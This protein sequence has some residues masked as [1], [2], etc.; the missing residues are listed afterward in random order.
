MWSYIFVYIYLYPIN[1]GLDVVWVKWFANLHIC[2][3][4]KLFPLTK[5]QYYITPLAIDQTYH[6]LLYKITSW[7]ENT[8]FPFT[9]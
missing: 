2:L 8:W 7:N 1:W 4:Y 6:S 9:A 3:P 5:R